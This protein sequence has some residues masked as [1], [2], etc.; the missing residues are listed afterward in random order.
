MM[1]DE[2]KQRVGFVIT[3]NRYA[4]SRPVAVGRGVG[5]GA[6]PLENAGSTSRSNKRSQHLQ[7]A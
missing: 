5:L 4:E 3:F 7:Y 6:F 1:S 2:I